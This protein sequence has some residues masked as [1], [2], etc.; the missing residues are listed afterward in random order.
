MKRHSTP[1]EHTPT[2]KRLRERRADG[3]ISRFAFAA[4]ISYIWEMRHGRS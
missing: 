2:I 3:L 1:D 4:A